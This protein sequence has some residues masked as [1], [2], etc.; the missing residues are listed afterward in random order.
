MLVSQIEQSASAWSEALT[1]ADGLEPGEAKAT[2]AIE[3]GRAL[4]QVLRRRGLIAQA[5]AVEEHT[6]R[7]KEGTTATVPA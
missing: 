6:V 7:L 4:A 5:Q 2:T 1:L 3:A